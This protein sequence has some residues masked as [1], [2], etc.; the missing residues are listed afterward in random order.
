MTTRI[1]IRPAVSVSRGFSLVELMIV[2]AIIVILVGLVLAVSTGL[3]RKSEDRVTRNVMQTLDASMREWQRQVDRPLTAQNTAAESGA[4]DVPFNPVL[5]NETNLL[6]PSSEGVLPPPY[7]SVLRAQRTIW[8][9]ELLGQQALARDMMSKLPEE[10]FRRTRTAAAVPIFFSLKECLD[11]WGNPIL[12]VFPGRLWVLGDV[13]TAD[14]D[15]TIR[16]AQEIDVLGPAA[17]V[18]AQCRNRQVLFVSAGPDGDLT[19]TADN[20]YSYGEEGQ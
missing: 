18:K 5:T 14:L 1:S 2:I 15:G 6:W 16:S 19:T 17:D 12:A 20:V 10:T 3:L 11:G 13:G 7:N 9:Y 8:L 4:Y